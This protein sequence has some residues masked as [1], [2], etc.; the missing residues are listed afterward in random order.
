MK[1]R[2][3]TPEPANT[4]DDFQSFARESVSGSGRWATAQ[5]KKLVAAGGELNTSVLR[6]ADTLRHEDWKFW[7]DVLQNEALIRL[8]GVQ[9]LIAA[10]LTK[11]IPNSL[12]KTVYDYEKITFM[13]EAEVSLDGVSRT[14]NDVQEFSQAGI[15]LPITHKDFFLNL[16]QLT[17]SRN[18]NTP[19][20][21][22]QAATAGRVVAEKAEKMLF[23]GGKTFG[24]L[25]IYGYTTF[26]SRNHGTFTSSKNWA[27][28]TKAGVDFVTDTLKAMTSLQ[29]ARQYG[30]YGIYVSTDAGVNIENDYIA[31]G[32]NNPN[33]TI[34]QRLEAIN[35]VSFVHVA[36]QCPSGHVI[37]T[38]LTG[39]NAVW[40]QGEPLQVVQWDEGG[41]FTI[42]FKAFQIAVP[43]FRVTAGGRSGV[44]D[45]YAGG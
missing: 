27:D 28:A 3:V 1:K 29:A 12:G 15:P 43:L 34:R 44:Y 39:D 14:A 16:R 6:T 22:V 19:L 4:F 31:T 26:P 25:P 9:D 18:S 42:N 23:Q 21:T 10:G 30:P 38:Q 41:G 45:M 8:V 36:D 32:G 40:V 5:L 20:D 24:G 37:F 11:S 17:A 35:N 2:I 33:Q 7:D 13:D